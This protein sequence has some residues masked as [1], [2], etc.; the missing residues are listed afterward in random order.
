LF[1]NDEQVVNPSKGIEVALEKPLFPT[2]GGF[3]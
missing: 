3:Y 1:V 2:G